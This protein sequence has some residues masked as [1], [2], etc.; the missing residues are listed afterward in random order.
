MRTSRLCLLL[1]TLLV[2]TPFAKAQ[3]V[4]ESIGDHIVRF[5]PDEEAR[6]NALPSF[7]LIEPNMEA[8]GDAPGDFP[9]EVDF[10]QDDEGRH[11]FTIEIEPGTSLYGTG[12]VP[13]PLQR[14]GRR[15]I[16]WNSDSYGY[17]DETLSLYKSHPWVLAVRAD[18]SSFGVIAD[19]TYR[20]EIDLTD[21]ITF[22]AEGPEYPV[23]VID[24]DS[25]QEVLIALA[26]LTGTMPMPPK[27]AIGYHQC[28]YSYYPD[29]QVRE[30]AEGFRERD[31][32]ADVIWMDIHYMDE[33]RV[34]RFDEERF[35][36]PKGLNEYL[37]DELN[38]HNVW[39][40]DPG[41]ASETDRFPEE[42]YSVYDELMAG[43]HAVKTASGEVYM[44]E[45]WPGETVF[46][47]Y[48]QQKT[49]DW[50]A[51]LYEDFMAQGITGVWNDMNEPAVFNVESKTMPE[52]NRHAGD[53]EMG[54]P[55]DHA[56]FHNVYGM[57][58]IKA[59]REGVQAANPEKRPFV[60]S[61]ATHLGGQRYA[62]GWS[63]DNSADWWDLEVSVPMV[64]NMGLSGFP[65]Y[66]PD[67][68]G[69]IGNGDAEQFERWF[70]FGVLFPFAR[71]HTAV[72]NRQKEPWAFG[73]EVETT[74][75]QALNNRYMLLPYYYTLFYEAHTT[76][77]PV[78][79]PAFFADPTDPALRT[80]DDIFLIGDA[81]LVRPDLTLHAD[82]V[83][84]MPKG[85]WNTLHL[86][87]AQNPDIPDFFVKGGSIIPLGPVMQYV[88]EKDLSPLTLIVSLDENGSARGDLYE[89]AGDGY[90]YQEGDYLL[91]T[92]EAVREGDEIVVSLVQEEGDRERSDR[93][94]RV[95]VLIGEGR[96]IQ[97]VGRDGSEIRLRVPPQ[98]ANIGN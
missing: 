85:I 79:R 4:S 9:V 50:W 31:L 15:T 19:S 38:F 58:M 53:P 65:F 11:S 10:F 76:G 96:E 51:G 16:L 81:L 29:S 64:L 44:G 84:T 52:D 25:P 41:I 47:D 1:V 33:Y 24:R 23:I 14:N 80:E 56:R 83:P 3:I 26:E 75:R 46:P 8:T 95:R 43:G 73:E 89:D 63:G 98:R 28:R 13:G 35:P 87:G 77:L 86:E 45:V 36:D 88:G 92:Y 61:R 34:F 90:D 71:G 57:L 22:Y 5:Y 82:R 48:T 66:G 32:P 12:E 68:G 67:I 74:A 93:P 30:I 94:L 40:I 17:K 54:G 37:L 2:S 20:I 97:T 6:E 59:T 69:F 27:W 70:G 42:G 55:G 7:A 18:G 72:G 39:M 62:A 21:D 60:L 49:R 78:A 91:S